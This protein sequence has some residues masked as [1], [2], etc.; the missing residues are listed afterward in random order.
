MVSN[1]TTIMSLFYLERLGSITHKQE[2]KRSEISS[3][4]IKHS[5]NKSF[6]VLI[7]FFTVN[8]HPHKPD[9]H[10]VSH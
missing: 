8:A 6:L 1:K 3:K 9:K 5:F 10:S 2:L 4:A 7:D